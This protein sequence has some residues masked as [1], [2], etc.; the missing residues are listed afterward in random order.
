MTAVSGN[1]GRKG[2]KRRG[3][4]ANLA[5]QQALMMHVRGGITSAVEVRELLMRPVL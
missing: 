1:N 2:R 3:N 5:L 4:A